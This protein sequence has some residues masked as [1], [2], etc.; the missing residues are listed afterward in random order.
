M[1][2]TA[3]FGCARSVYTAHMTPLLPDD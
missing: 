2:D 1:S 3:V